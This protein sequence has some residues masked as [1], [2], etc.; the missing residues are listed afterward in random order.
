[1]LYST[2]T[3]VQ[4]HRYVAAARSQKRAKSTVY[5]LEADRS[6]QLKCLAIEDQQTQVHTTVVQYI[7]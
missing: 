5:F 4:Y 7:L 1:M 2:Y 6:D 3:A